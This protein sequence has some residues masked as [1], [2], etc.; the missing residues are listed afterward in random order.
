MNGGAIFR[1][2]PVNPNPAGAAN[3]GVLNFQY[4][5]RTEGFV[6]LVIC[7]ELGKEV[8]RVIDNRYLPA[9]TYRVG[10]NISPLSE[11]TY[12]YR[13]TLNNKNATSG[14]VVIQK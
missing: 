13:F 11:G 5:S 14:R 10:Y 4:A 8:A 3:G 7:D 1:A 6:S 9:G 2:F 12:V